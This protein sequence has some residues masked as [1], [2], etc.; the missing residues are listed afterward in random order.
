MIGGYKG[1]SPSSRVIRWRDWSE[2]SHMSWIESGVQDEYESWIKGGVQHVDRFGLNHRPGTVIDLFD[3]DLTPGEHDGLIGFYE[4]QL[5]KGYDFRAL[6]GFSLRIDIHDKKALFC[7][8][9]IFGGFIE[10]RKPLLERIPAWK[11]PPAYIPLSPLLK[12]TGSIFV[13]E[14]SVAPAENPAIVNRHSSIG[15]LEGI[16]S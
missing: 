4:S 10:I 5:G 8:E 12:F 13:P 1:T 11:V 9:Y 6:L 7:S 16:L 14:Y 2:Y 15:N 3:I